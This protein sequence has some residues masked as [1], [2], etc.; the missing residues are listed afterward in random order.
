MK[1]FKYYHSYRGY[2]NSIVN[3]KGYTLAEDE[4]RAIA[5]VMEEH[6]GEGH[7]NLTE[8]KVIRI[9]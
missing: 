7:V 6:C 8:V 5:N 1:I 3:D 4:D 2:N 9:S